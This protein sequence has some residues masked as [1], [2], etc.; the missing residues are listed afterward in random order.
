MYPFFVAQITHVVSCMDDASGVEDDSWGGI[1]WHHMLTQFFQDEA[2]EAPTYIHWNTFLEPPGP[3][4]HNFT[5]SIQTRDCGYLIEC[6]SGLLQHIDSDS[7]V[8]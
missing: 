5:I 6:G 7:V 3:S 1:A 8:S 2:E 4:L